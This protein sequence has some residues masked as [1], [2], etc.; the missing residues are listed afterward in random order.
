MTLEKLKA[1][2]ES[3]A[4]TQ[5]EFNE[6]S[7]GLTES[8]QDQGQDPE[9]ELP[10]DV[11]KRIEAAVT[12]AAGKIAED[13]KRLAEQLRKIKKE[14]LTAE[15][16]QKLDLQEKEQLLLEREAALR[17]KENRE[18]ALKAIKKAGLDDGSDRA[19]ELV[20]F[21]LAEDEA[22]I[23]TRVKAFNDLFRKMLKA[24]VDRTFKENGREPHSG[25]GSGATV[26]PYAKET[27]NFTAQ[28]ELELS[29]P[30]EAKRLRELAGI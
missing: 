1:L 4:I 28:N 19:L 17:E 12:K 9:T 16:S 2:L 7:A 21:V 23:D 13:N 29:N 20:D 15:E 22:Q 26:N 25:S 11:E 3:G 24:E 10:D 27:W 6:M 14:K 30:Q 8:G 5:E 18:Y